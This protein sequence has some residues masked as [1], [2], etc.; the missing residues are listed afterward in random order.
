MKAIALL[1]GAGFG[2]MLGWARLTDYDVVRSMLLLREPDLYLM[3]GSAMATAAVGARLLR[4]LHARAWI[5]G[6][7]VSW[8]ST[9]PSRD[10]LL[11]SAVFGV[12]WA[13]AGTCP[14]PVAAQLGRGQWAAVFTVSGILVGV[15]LLGWLKARRAQVQA[16]KPGTGG[17]VVAPGL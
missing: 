13:I 6:A 14:G 12:G 10:H 16:A 4:A 3:M 11:G 17:S 1:V 15:W 5:G 9:R 8:G 7:P 2:F